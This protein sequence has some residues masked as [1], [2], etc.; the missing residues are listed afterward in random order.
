MPT[1]VLFLQLKLD[2]VNSEITALMQVV[3]HWESGNDISSVVRSHLSEMVVRVLGKIDNEGPG[4]ASSESSFCSIDPP[5]T[6][7]AATEESEKSI[8]SPTDRVMPPQCNSRLNGWAT[9]QLYDSQAVASIRDS[10]FPP[11]VSFMRELTF[12]PKTEAKVRS[13]LR[14]YTSASCRDY[15]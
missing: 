6:S 15:V 4:A 13:S 1:K 10:S 5:P 11:D 3:P 14:C 8:N 9:S 2:E 7:D 12:P